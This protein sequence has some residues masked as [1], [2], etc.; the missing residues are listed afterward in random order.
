[1]SDNAIGCLKWRKRFVENGK[2]KKLVARVLE[3]DTIQMLNL[4][5][6]IKKIQKEWKSVSENPSLQ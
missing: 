5:R 4:T 1:M 2:I 6:K 3:E